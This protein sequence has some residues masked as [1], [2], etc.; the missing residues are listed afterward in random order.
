V[1]TYAT[2]MASPRMASLRALRGS[3]TTTVTKV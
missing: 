3:G 2:E 1:K